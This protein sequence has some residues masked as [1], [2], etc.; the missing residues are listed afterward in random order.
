MSTIILTINSGSQHSDVAFLRR[1]S[2]GMTLVSPS[3]TSCQ[4]FLQTGIQAN[5]AALKRMDRFDASGVSSNWVWSVGVG[6]RAIP[7]PTVGSHLR[8][9]TS[10]AQA[11]NRSLSLIVG[12][13]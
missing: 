6:N 12:G 1:A 9:E 3:L 8:V 2:G 13:L 10:V 4:L 5:S 7:L 11:D